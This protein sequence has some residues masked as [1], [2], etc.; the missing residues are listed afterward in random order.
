MY[1]V[2]SVENASL[3]GVRGVEAGARRE[4]SP[5]SLQGLL[6]SLLRACGVWSGLEVVVLEAVAVAF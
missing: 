4:S 1:P 6:T 5:V 3:V 2:A